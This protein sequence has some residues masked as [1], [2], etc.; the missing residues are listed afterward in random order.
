MIVKA[1]HMIRCGK[2]GALRCHSRQ[3]TGL[4][5]SDGPGIQPR[6]P[7]PRRAAERRPIAGKWMYFVGFVGRPICRR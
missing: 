5:S 6:S 2:D 3:S 7:R 1:C 4:A